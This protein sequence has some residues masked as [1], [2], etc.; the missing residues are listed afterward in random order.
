[1]KP[2][3]KR[4][5]VNNTSVD[6]SGMV[7][8]EIRKC[9]FGGSGILP[10]ELADLFKITIVQYDEG[11]RVIVDFADDRESDQNREEHQMK[12]YELTNET[13]EAFGKQ[14]HR[15]RALRD[16][17]NVKAGDFGGFVESE[18]NLNQ[19]VNCWISENARVSGDAM[20][21]GDARV[22]GNAR[23]LGYVLVYGHTK[24]CA[25]TR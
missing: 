23:I 15:I 10:D 19:E 12:K 3:Y 2:K 4:L 7:E 13:I 21:S 8:T 20:V 24:V 18:T 14:P 6:I 1:M 16:F 17:G 11:P 9:A 22:L 25:D 5:L